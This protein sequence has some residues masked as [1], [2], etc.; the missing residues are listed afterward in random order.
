[1]VNAVLPL[2]EHQYE[3]MRRWANGDFDSVETSRREHLCDAL[4][5]IALE[6]CCGG[7]FHP[8]IDAPRIMRNPHVYAAPYR[9]KHS[10]GAH[11]AVPAATSETNF[12]GLVAGQ[13]T[14]GMAVPWQAD[15]YDCQQERGNSWWPSSRPDDVLSIK[16]PPSVALDSLSD[17]TVRWD[18]PLDDYAKMVRDWAGLGIVR[19]REA[20]PDEQSKDEFDERI[21][22]AEVDSSGIKRYYYYGETERVRDETDE[23]FAHFPKKEKPV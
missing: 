21:Y 13:V 23:R 7:A 6:A 3:H 14:E 11:T 12:D 9:F 15:F 22:N 10:S 16:H 20:R 2:L 8:G 1:M 4:D 17:F 5:R 19:R 18:F